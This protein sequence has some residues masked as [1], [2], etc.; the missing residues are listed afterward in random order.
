MKLFNKLMLCAVSCLSLTAFANEDQVSKENKAYS[1]VSYSLTIVKNNNGKESVYESH[2]SAGQTAFISDKKI[3]SYLAEKSCEDKK[4]CENIKGTEDI[5]TEL[6][7]SVS[8]AVNSKEDL[9]VYLH[10]LEKDLIN[11]RQLCDDE[12]TCVDIFDK[13]FINKKDTIKMR[14]GETK[15]LKVNNLEY[16]ITLRKD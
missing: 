1:E 11:K 9:I 5:G 14:N 12:K 6:T 13:V 3:V 16:K 7:V 2:V 15:E 8:K 10:I 4:N